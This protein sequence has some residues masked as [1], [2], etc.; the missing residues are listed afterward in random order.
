MDGTSASEYRA[1]AGSAR[2]RIKKKKQ[3]N[4]KNKSAV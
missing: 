3:Q 1:V 2:L 4:R